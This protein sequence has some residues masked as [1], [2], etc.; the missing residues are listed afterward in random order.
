MGYSTKFLGRLDIA[1]P[2]NDAEVDW[3][4][5]FAEIDR[6]HYRN[7]YD[8]AM[9]PRVVEQER[10]QG[11]RS[12]DESTPN[13]FSTLS[14]RDGSPYPHLDWVPCI[15]GCCLLWNGTEKSRM[16]LEW[17]EYLTDHFLRPG[18]HA[19]DSG[20]REFEHFT[21]DHQVNGT[22]A[23]ERDDTGELFLIRA[24]DNVFDVET[25]DGPQWPRW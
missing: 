19:H 20:R 17:L 21:F 4:R 18:A 25:L 12:K 3:L 2:L 11:P 24:R 5:A 22:L 8:V 6:R 10:A 15:D 13:P 1:P 9:N 16:A 7:P 14:P 23:G